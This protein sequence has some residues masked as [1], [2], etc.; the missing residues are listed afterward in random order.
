MRKPFSVTRK[1]KFT[2]PINNSFKK[3]VHKTFWTEHNH[4]VDCHKK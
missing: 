4:K 1:L 3:I 2:W